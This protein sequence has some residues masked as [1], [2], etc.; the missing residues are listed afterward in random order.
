MLISFQN[1]IAGLRLIDSSEDAWKKK[2]ELEN[3]KYR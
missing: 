1:Y 3:A 2:H